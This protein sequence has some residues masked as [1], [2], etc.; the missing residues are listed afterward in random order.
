MSKY[1]LIVNPYG[2][3]K[4]GM[5]ILEKV[6]PVFESA[7][8][9]LT[10][11]ETQYA[12]HARNMARTEKFEGYDGFC[13]IGGDGTMHEVINGMM[14]R[15]DGQQLPLGIIPGGT[16]NSF[17]RDLD[18]L[19]PVNAAK[20]IITNRRRPIDISKVNANGETLYAFNIVGWGMPTEIII[21]AEKLRWLGSQRYNVASLIEII[22][23]RERL[24][25]LV[26]EGNRTV[27]D[28][29]FIL[30]CNTIHTG[31]GMKM[32]PLAQLNDGYIDLIVVHKASRWKLL[33][34]FP[35]VFSGKHIADPIVEYH[36][37]KTFSIIPKEEHL[38]N[39]DGEL[40]GNTPI[41]VEVM[42]SAIDV[43]V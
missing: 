15:E 22:A 42:P 25:T 10:I 40:L 36:Q 11:L 8:A 3:D 21:L 17:M 4:K 1:Y 24:A 12:G 20:R 41:D 33:K 9:E 2:G 18:C 35:K 7:G 16:G 6:K 34:M 43:L 37:V 19:D 38:L 28:F 39:I 27:G 30:G 31:A 5:A 13:A 14:N 23:F 29:G 32:A 26:I